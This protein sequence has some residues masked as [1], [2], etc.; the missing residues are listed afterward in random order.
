MKCVGNLIL[1]IILAK[2]LEK[3]NQN[4]KCIWIERDEKIAISKTWMK[5]RR[6]GAA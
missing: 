5:W 1:Q 4:Y 3:Q 6:R 2:N